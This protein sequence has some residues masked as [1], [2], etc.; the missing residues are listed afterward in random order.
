MGG[1]IAKARRIVFKTM[2]PAEKGELQ[3][4]VQVETVAQSG[5]TGI[6]GSVQEW[7]Q[8]TK[9]WIALTWASEV[10]GIVRKTKSG[11]IKEA[12]DEWGQEFLFCKKPNEGEIR[13]MT[14]TQKKHYLLRTTVAVLESFA[15]SEQER[16]LWAF[17]IVDTEQVRELAAEGAN[18]NQSL[19]AQQDL[20]II[21]SKALTEFALHIDLR[22]LQR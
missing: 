5:V 17:E 15:A 7:S 12:D 8:E 2:T 1:L 4:P 22:T 14:A 20:T 16:L 18:R 19:F 11:E 3:E 9:E 21:P 6:M 10:A 13:N